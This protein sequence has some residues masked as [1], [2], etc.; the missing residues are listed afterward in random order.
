[1]FAVGLLIL[2]GL[3]LLGNDIVK[4]ARIIKGTRE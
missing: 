3:I 2:I 4:A 1:M